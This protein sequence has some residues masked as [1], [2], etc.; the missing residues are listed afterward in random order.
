[1]GKRAPRL[2]FTEEERA[3]PELKKA[4]RK[5]DKAADKLEKAEAKIPKKTVK[6]KERVLDEKTGKIKTKLT[7]E[8]LEKKTPSKLSH[9]V[10]SAPLNAVSVAAHREIHESEDDNVGVEGAH[11]LEEV[12]EGGVRMI[13]SAH[14]SHQLKPYRNAAHAEARAD[15]ANLRVLNK[16]SNLQNPHLQSNPYSRWQQKQAIKKEYAAA[17]AGKSAG[18]TVKASEATAKAAKK[19]AEETKKTTEFIVRHRKGFLIVGLLA[20]MV[21]FLLNVASSCSVLV[22]SGVSAFGA[23]TYPVEDADM[24]AA[25]AQYCAMEAEL[26]EYLDTYERMHDYDEYHYNLD[27]I[28][29][30]PYVLISAITALHGSEWTVD[31]VGGILELLFEKQYILTETVETETRYRTETRIG[32]RPARDPDTGEYLYD[33][34]GWLI[35]EEYTYQVDV[36]YTY[37]ICTVELENFNLSHVPVY[38]MSQDQLSMYAMYMGT[39]GNRPELFPGSGYVGMY[40]GTEYEDYEIPAEAL[41]DEQFAAIMA[42]AEKYLGFPYVWGGSSP[43]T[44]FDCSGFVSWVY[45]NCGVGWSFGRLGAE[46]LRGICTRVSPSNAKPGDLIFFQGTYD[47]TGAS[48]VGIYVGNNKMLHCGDPIQYADITSSYWQAHFLSFGRLP[49][50]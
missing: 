2:Q 30:D 28:E 18:K 34:D 7:F 17:K 14:R 4:I 23:S 47:T 29:H 26:Q 5:A 8:E 41:A 12:A 1:M 43:S 35:W 44:S 40:Y 3:A 32:E 10:V 31:E 27:D 24:L 6:V 19:T 48:H 39:L 37:Y 45:N 38:I 36:P 25:E 20:L 22:Q 42:E 13:D 33:E 11:K 15:K 50:P 21:V 49:S 9:A 46:G 16:T